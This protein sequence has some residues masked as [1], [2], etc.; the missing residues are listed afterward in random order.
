MTSKPII[1]VLAG[2]GPRSTA[3]FI[4]MLID[5]CQSHY[6]ARHDEDFPTIVAISQPTPFRLDREPDGAAMVAAMRSGL[7]RL[8]HAGASFVAVP[9]NVAHV[10]LDALVADGDVPVIDMVAE[11]VN[12]VPEGARVAVLA[13]P[14]TCASG[15]YQ[16]RLHDAGVSV[17]PPA[18]WQPRV[19]GV[20]DAVKR[21]ALAEARAD[22]PGLLDDMQRQGGVDL[23]VCACTDLTPVL[24]DTGTLRVVDA[25]QVLAEVSVERWLGR[26]AGDSPASSP[27]RP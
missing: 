5:A 22:I 15:L 27:T 7:R 9:C 24:P 10:W 1:G 16:R 17:A 11:T 23:V 19:T 20:I 26:G 6:G 2:M 3:P 8:Q 14:A 18:D 12:R 13:T 21:G 25:A 4:D